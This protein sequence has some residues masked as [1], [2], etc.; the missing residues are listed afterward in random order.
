MLNGNYLTQYSSD[1]ETLSPQSSMFLKNH[2]VKELA[3][4]DACNDDSQK[5]VFAI[6]PSDGEI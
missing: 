3:T 1:D 5:F 2:T 4:S 6:Y